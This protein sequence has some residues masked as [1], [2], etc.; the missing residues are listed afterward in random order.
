[1]TAAIFIG[2]LVA[3]AIVAGVM[4]GWLVERKGIHSGDAGPAAAFWPATVLIVG[5]AALAEWFGM[6]GR[7]L[8]RPRQKRADIPKAKVVRK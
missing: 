5:L 7:W 2:S 8:F 6:A 3:Y 1:V 4:F